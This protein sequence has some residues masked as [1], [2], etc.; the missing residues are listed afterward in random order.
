VLPEGSLEIEA[1]G[2]ALWLLPQCAAF[3]PRMNM[4][5]I[6]DAHLGKAAAFRNGGIPVPSG[7]TNENL[8]AVDGLVRACGA[9]Q[10]V[11]LGDLVHS[12]AARRAAS[13]AF[14]KWR[15]RN[16]ALEVVL[17]RGNHDR[18][19]GVVPGQW[20]VTSVEE[21]YVTGPFALSHAPAEVP[22][23]YA[24]AGHTHPCVNLHGRGREHLRLPCFW[25]TRTYAVLP[26]FG[27][28]TGMA[29]VEPDAS[30][31]VYVSAGD[32]VLAVR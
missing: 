12:L 8:D 32:R 20:R 10:L 24:I 22:G 2:E 23:S 18:R 11:F 30:D 1:A 16:A 13:D 19:A 9:K 6:A 4:L 25:F 31:R 3:W 28:F 5:L 26:A 29:D 17:V 21:P 27:A 15:E 14:L 7:T